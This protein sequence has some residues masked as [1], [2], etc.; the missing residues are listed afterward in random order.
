MAETVSQT[1]VQQVQNT[2]LATFITQVNAVLATYD[3]SGQV[4][5]ANQFK[6]VLSVVYNEAVDSSDVVTYTAFITTFNAQGTPA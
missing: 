4:G 6:S 3:G 1:R 2:V 5:N